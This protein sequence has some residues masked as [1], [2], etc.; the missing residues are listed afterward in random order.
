MSRRL[1][2]VRLALGGVLAATT[3]GGFSPRA[4]PATAAV[5]HDGPFGIAMGEPLAELGPVQVVAPGTYQVMAPVRPNNVLGTV[6]VAAF[7]NLGVCRIIGLSSRNE[8]DSSG[9]LARATTDQVAATLTQKYGQP[10]KGADCY[11][12]SDMCSGFWTTEVYKGAASYYYNWKTPTAAWPAN[13]GSIQVAVRASN[14]IATRV[15]LIYSSSD[16]DSCSAAI[17]AAA[18][19]S[20]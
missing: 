20:L 9:S 2:L 19:A 17:K 1:N 4:A 16:D 10:T 13:I 11:A 8:F 12:S 3:V 5:N 15:S 14:E 7:P 6:I 18:G